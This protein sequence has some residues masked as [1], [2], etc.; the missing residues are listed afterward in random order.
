VVAFGGSIEQKPLI[1]EALIAF[2]AAQQ[3]F[4]SMA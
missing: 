3:A 1:A 4:N 2:L